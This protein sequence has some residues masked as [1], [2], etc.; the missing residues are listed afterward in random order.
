MPMEIAELSHLVSLS[1]T[2]EAYVQEL[3][4][5]NVHAVTTGRA[6]SLEVSFAELLAG[7]DP[8]ATSSDQMRDLLD[9]K[10][11]EVRDT[12]SLEQISIAAE[13]SAGSYRSIAEAYGRV[14]GLYRTSL[15]K[16]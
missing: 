15:G 9:A 1:M 11:V 10:T 12:P 5:K 16:G 2:Y 4:A 8:G 6:V 7:I 13:K 14:L 3:N